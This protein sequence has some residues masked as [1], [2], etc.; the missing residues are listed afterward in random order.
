MRQPDHPVKVSLTEFLTLRKELLA[1]RAASKRLSKE[2]EENRLI[3]VLDDISFNKVEQL[4]GLLFTVVDADAADTVYRNIKSDSETVY[5]KGPDEGG[6]ASAHLVIDLKTRPNVFRYRAGLEDVEGVSR[7]RVQPFLQDLFRTY[8]GQA[9]VVIDGEQFEG[10][11]VVEIQAVQKDKLSDAAGRP[12]S[13]ELVHVQPRHKLDGVGEERYHERKMTREFSIDRKQPV[14]KALAALF[15]IRKRQQAEFKAYPMMRIR[16]KRDDERTQ[17][18]RVENLAD[19]LNQRAFTRLELID[20]FKDHL[21]SATKVIR[22]DVFAKICD[23]VR[24]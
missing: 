7:S 9:K 24:R 13:V 15:D 17:T 4:I 14:G 5:K 22:Q 11:P 19:D 18:L 21:V 6:A 20:G 16:W 8:I 2:I 10:D 3:I 1:A 23:V 12:L